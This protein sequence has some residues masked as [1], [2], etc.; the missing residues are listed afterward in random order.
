MR[1]Q[2]V[3]KYLTFAQEGLVPEI[4]CPM[5][6]GLLMCNLDDNDKIFLYCLSCNYKKYIG[7]DFYK[8]IEEKLKEIKNG[9]I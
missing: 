7:L 3:S 1:V 2:V 8:K 4:N 6:Q 9:T 5:D